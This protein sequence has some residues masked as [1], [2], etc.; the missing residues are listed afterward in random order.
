MMPADSQRRC[1]FAKFR[2]RRHSLSTPTHVTAPRI[3]APVSRHLDVTDIGR[4]IAFYRD[5]LGFEIEAHAGHSAELT[6][7]PA[8]VTLGRRG[9]DDGAEARSILFFET[10]DV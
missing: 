9:P 5:M 6:L 4:T 2:L 8:R 3:V 7:G 10:D 1:R